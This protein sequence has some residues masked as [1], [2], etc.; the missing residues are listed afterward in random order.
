MTRTLPKQL[1]GASRERDEPR[2]G[3]SAVWL[4][5]ENVHA[6]FR[7]RVFR[8]V[9]FRRQCPRQPHHRDIASYEQLEDWRAAHPMPAATVAEVADHVEHVRAVAGIDHVGLGGDFD[10]TSHLPEGLSDVSGYP[11]LFAELIDRGWSAAD[12]GKLASGNILRVLRDARDVVS[13][14]RQAVISA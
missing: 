8:T 7:R 10:G 14:P 13:Q 3:P 11:S 4:T 5:L 6:L 9:H 1:I 12:C 2:D